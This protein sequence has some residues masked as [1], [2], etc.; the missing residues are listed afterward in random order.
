LA[1]PRPVLEL[2]TSRRR[3]AAHD[4]DADTLGRLTG[5]PGLVWVGAFL[6]V[7]VAALAVGARLLL[8]GAAKN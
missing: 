7:T 4:S 3:G 8:A 2:Q 5:V 1:A 6:L